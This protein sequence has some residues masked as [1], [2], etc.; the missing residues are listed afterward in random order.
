MREGGM[1]ED[2]LFRLNASYV[3][4][5]MAQ[6]AFFTGDPDWRFLPGILVLLFSR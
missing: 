6:A 3:S 2:V 4:S 5:V 1:E